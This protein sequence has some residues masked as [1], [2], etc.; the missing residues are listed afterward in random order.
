M[1]MGVKANGGTGRGR[2]RAA[3]DGGYIKKLQIKCEVCRFFGSF[4]PFM[5]SLISVTFFRRRPVQGGTRLWFESV[6][7]IL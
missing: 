1:R 7:W 5:A 2:W 3:T 6:D 4:P